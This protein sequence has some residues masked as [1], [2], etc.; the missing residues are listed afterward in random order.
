MCVGARLVA[1]VGEHKM[2]REM[3]PVN[4]YFSQAPCEVYFGLGEHTQVD[5]L[6]IHWPSGEVQTL[7][8]VAGDQ[9]LLVTEGQHSLIS[10]RKN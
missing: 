7:T 2:V 1:E 8:N 4:T 10:A 5:K 9:R 6:T 3:Y